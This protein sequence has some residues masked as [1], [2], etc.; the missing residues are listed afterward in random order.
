MT[1]QECYQALGGDH[2]EVLRRLMN[3]QLVRKFLGRFAQDDSYRNLCVELVQGNRDAAFRAAHTLKGV[4]ANLGLGKLLSSA[5]AVTEILRPG[6]AMTDQEALEAARAAL[7]EV[8]MGYEEALD[9]IN[10]FLAENG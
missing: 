6:G 10:R 2:N 3:E 4:C 7:P 5:E 9:I 8:N 1:I